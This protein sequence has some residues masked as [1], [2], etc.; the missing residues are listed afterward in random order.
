MIKLCGR[1]QIKIVHTVWFHLYKILEK[2]YKSLVTESRSVVAW[3]FMEKRKRQE[4]A[5]TKG[6]KRNL[7]GN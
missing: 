5:T 7:E 4:E 1:S 2:V 6:Q 3:G